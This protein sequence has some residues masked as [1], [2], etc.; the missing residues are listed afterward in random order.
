MILKRSHLKQEDGSFYTWD[1]LQDYQQ[2]GMAFILNEGIVEC[3][4]PGHDKNGRIAHGVLGINKIENGE[5]SIH[6]EDICRDLRQFIR[7][8][9]DHVNSNGSWSTN[10]GLEQY[11]QF[12]DNHKELW[13]NDSE[14]EVESCTI[15]SLNFQVE[16]ILQ[17]QA[18]FSMVCAFVVSS[19]MIHYVKTSTIREGSTRQVLPLQV[20]ARCPLLQSHATK[21]LNRAG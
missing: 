11:T 7:K 8:G 13:G 5:I 12:R 18:E 10:F 9:S 21:D 15:F 6:G 3:F 4:P 17:F 14:R 1:S 20:Q 2:A 19:L 16:P